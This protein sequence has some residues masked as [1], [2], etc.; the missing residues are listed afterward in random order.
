MGP[1]WTLLLT[2]ER[3]TGIPIMA[4]ETRRADLMLSTNG[5]SDADAE[6]TTATTK[7][8]T[9]LMLFIVLH[10]PDTIPYRSCGISSRAYYLPSFFSVSDAISHE[11]ALC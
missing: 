10:I 3:V 7:L 11:P 5:A 9:I 6:A 2:H 8:P 1:E 4:A